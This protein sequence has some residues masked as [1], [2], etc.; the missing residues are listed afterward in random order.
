M[1]ATLATLNIRLCMQ[2]NSYVFE[3]SFHPAI[4]LG[5]VHCRYVFQRYYQQTAASTFFFTV[6]KRITHPWAN[7]VS[8]YEENVVCHICNHTIKFLANKTKK[9][10]RPKCC[11]TQK[12]KKTL[13]D[14][15]SVTK[16]FRTQSLSHCQTHKVSFVEEIPSLQPKLSQLSKH[17]RPQWNPILT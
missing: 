7:M 17:W 5:Q 9:K 2:W 8:K 14:V 1:R 10:S 11:L 3:V 15:E 6:D 4:V 12:W 16:I 13:A